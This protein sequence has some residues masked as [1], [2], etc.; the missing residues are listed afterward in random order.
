MPTTTLIIDADLNKLIAAL[1]A[2]RVIQQKTP[3]P[4]RLVGIGGGAVLVALLLSGHDEDL[5]QILNRFNGSAHGLLHPD[6]LATWLKPHVADAPLD[7][8]GNNFML[9]ANLQNGHP[10]ILPFD[11]MTWGL[12][13]ISLIDA[14]T[15]SARPPW[16]NDTK[17]YFICDGRL[18]SHDTLELLSAKTTIRIF[19]EV[20]PSTALHGIGTENR[21]TCTQTGQ[22]AQAI[23]NKSSDMAPRHVWDEMIVIHTEI[24]PTQPR[25]TLDQFE[26]LYRR[27]T[28]AA[29]KWYAEGVC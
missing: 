6:A 16:L 20:D 21:T 1:G 5:E 14:T 8:F 10:I 7:S 24:C 15:L 17:H 27:G 11:G 29:K 12:P 2:L 26:D 22:H 13:D 23:R 4:Y 19:T 3:G 9:A 25:L 18:C 28:D